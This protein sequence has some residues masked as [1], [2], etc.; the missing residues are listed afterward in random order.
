MARAT[1]WPE[2]RPQVSWL[3]RLRCG[4]TW[5]GLGVRRDGG[6][7]EREQHA[8]DRGVDLLVVLDLA[9]A[10]VEEG[11]PADVAAGAG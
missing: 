6:K 2:G 5:G 10:E 11:L 9:V 7:W 3:S 8:G 4:K 1:A